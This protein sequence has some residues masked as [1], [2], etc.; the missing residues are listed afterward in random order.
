MLHGSIRMDKV[1]TIII[2]SILT[3]RHTACNS[4][5][6]LSRLALHPVQGLTVGTLRNSLGLR[7]KTGGKHFG[8]DKQISIR[9][10]ADRFVRPCHIGLW[11]GPFYISL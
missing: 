10:T 3:Y 2:V 8:Q 6:P 7:T 11:I 9:Q 1:K 4:T 5:I